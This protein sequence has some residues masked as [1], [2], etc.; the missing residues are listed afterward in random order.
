MPIV[1]DAVQKASLEDGNQRP[2]RLN[3]VTQLIDGA[4]IL[5]KPQVSRY[6]SY[7]HECLVSAFAVNPRAT[8]NKEVGCL[9][10]VAGMHF[11]E[12]KYAENIGKGKSFINL[13]WQL[14][15]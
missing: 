8:E 3:I 2:L 4:S 14:I 12:K 13:S 11:L 15:Y 9:A 10:L 6:D 7:L 5:Q 1:L